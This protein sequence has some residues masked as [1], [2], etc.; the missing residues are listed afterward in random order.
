MQIGCAVQADWA[1]ITASHD[2]FRDNAASSNSTSHNSS[3]KNI[4]A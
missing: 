3:E 4:A 2:T 1:Q